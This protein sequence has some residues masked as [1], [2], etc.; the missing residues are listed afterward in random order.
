MI[1]WLPVAAIF[2]ATL[3]MSQGERNWAFFTLT[4]RPVL[5]AAKRR[6]VWR[7]RKAGIWRMS[8]TSAAGAA[9]EAAWMSVRVGR[10]RSGFILGRVS[11]PSERPGRREAF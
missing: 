2:S 3:P 8:A 6:L 1:F 11:V 7:E 4:M 5:A 9:W 10:W